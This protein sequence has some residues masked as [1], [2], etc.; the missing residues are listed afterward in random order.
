MIIAVRTIIPTTPYPDSNIEG[1]SQGQN[2]VDRPPAGYEELIA[3]RTSLIELLRD[4]LGG[5]DYYYHTWRN[6]PVRI[7]SKPFCRQKDHS[8]MASLRASAA[9]LVLPGLIGW[10]GDCC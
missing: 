10:V 7:L 4:F 2:S 6:P 8:E 3:E 5:V 9:F 1:T